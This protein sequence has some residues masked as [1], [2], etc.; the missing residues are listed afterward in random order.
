MKVVTR[1]QISSNNGMVKEVRAIFNWLELYGSDNK[2]RPYVVACFS[3]MQCNNPRD[4]IR[5]VALC[6]SYVLTQHV[7]SKQSS[8]TVYGA[9]LHESPKPTTFYKML[10]IRTRRDMA[11]YTQF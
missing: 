9:C 7:E 2:C 5:E 1:R 10:E 4:Y 8:F 11:L 3:S 6:N